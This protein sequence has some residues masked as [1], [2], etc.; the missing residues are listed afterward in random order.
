M[1]FY[2]K[3][4]NLKIFDLPILLALQIVCDYADVYASGC[5]VARAFSLYSRKTSSKSLHSLDSSEIA[6]ESTTEKHLNVEFICPDK[7]E[8]FELSLIV[9]K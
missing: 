1:L 3:T 2:N 9:N 7:K 5:A 4:K 6:P 8:V